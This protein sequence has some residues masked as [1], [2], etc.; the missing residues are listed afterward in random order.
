MKKSNICK[1]KMKFNV[2]II[3]R[4]ME[5]FQHFQ[6]CF[7]EIHLNIAQVSSPRI[8]KLKLVFSEL[9]EVYLSETSCPVLTV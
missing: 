9:S 7:F 4:L 5:F 1:N 6:N 8:S 2:N 3:G